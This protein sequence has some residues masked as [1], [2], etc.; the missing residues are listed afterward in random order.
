MCFLHAYR[1]MFHAGNC[2]GNPNCEATVALKNA[3]VGWGVQGHEMAA[4]L[5]LDAGT[6]VELGKTLTTYTG[7]AVADG[8]VRADT[9]AR[10]NVRLY[11][12]LIRAGFLDATADDALGPAD[13]DTARAR[14]LAYEAATD[15][16]VLLKNEEDFLPLSSSG[17]GLKLALIGPHLNSTKDLQASTGYAGENKLVLNNTIEAAFQRRARASNGAVE[18]VGVAQGC[19]IVVGCPSVDT[20][21]ITVAVANADVVVAFVGLHPASGAPA[22]PGYGTACAESEAWDRG[23]IALCGQQ[24]LLLETALA[25]GKPLVTVLINGGMQCHAL[26]GGG[27]VV[28]I[29]DG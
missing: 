18:I 10:S 3:S 20:A 13:V 17:A 21:A 1:L 8:L 24:Q 4:E 6:D 2:C 27:G 16:M 25:H 9:V 28:S 19:D 23:D 7:G 12:E 29:V 11:T 14:H 22:Y 26:C 15:A 5:C